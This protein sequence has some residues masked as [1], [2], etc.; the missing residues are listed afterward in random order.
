MGDSAFNLYTISGS[1]VYKLLANGTT[2]IFHFLSNG[3]LAAVF[4]H[5]DAAIPL[6]DPHYLAVSPSGTL[7]VADGYNA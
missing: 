3:S 5:H 4:T 1:A 7:L 6:W 2:Y